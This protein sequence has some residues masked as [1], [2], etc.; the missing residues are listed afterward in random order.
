MASTDFPAW[1]SAGVFGGIGCALLSAMT[2]AAWA[3]WRRR[4]VT[5]QAIAALLVTVVASALDIGP[6]LWIEYR[7]N[8]YGPTLS[9][10]EVAAA[11]VAATL[12]GWVAPLGTLCWYLL[13]AAPTRA[14]PSHGA[15]G[16]TVA[17]AA[18]DD[19]DRAQAVYVGGQ[20]WGLLAPVEA[21]EASSSATSSRPIVLSQRLT[22]IGREVDNDL[23][24]DDERISRRHAELRWDHGRIE[25]ADYGSLNG[26]RVNEQA[27]RGRLLLRDGDIIELGKRRFRLVVQADAGSVGMPM[28]ASGEND[29]NGLEQLETRKTS[30]ASDPSVFGRPALR[31][32]LLQGTTSAPGASWLLSAAVTMVGRDPACGVS[33]AD[34]SISRQH[35]QV[36]RQ[37]AGY[38]IADL[39]SSNGVFLNGQ[40]LTGPAQMFAGDIVMLGDVL[41]RCE[42]VTAGVGNP[43]DAPSVPASEQYVE[44][45]AA[46]AVSP[47]P[48]MAPE[49]H[50]RMTP[51][52]N[53]RR[54]SRPRLAP[55]RLRPT[56]PQ[57]DTPPA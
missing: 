17:P 28:G 6:L 32:V 53:A 3:L 21:P 37:P 50:T 2:I 42:E 23:V 7:L 27:A 31:L 44:T 15:R 24:L 49:F 47:A 38:F 5:G 41:L 10:S 26:T 22:L 13:Q 9:V 46:P 57:R 29:D 1:Y 40:R 30:R 39:Q 33:L 45:P 54:E 55:P 18:L 16:A 43:P 48:A 56:P 12:V 35:A 25:L 34:T 20:P 11:L 14:T 19:P 36:T 52:W 4:A 8:V 51:L